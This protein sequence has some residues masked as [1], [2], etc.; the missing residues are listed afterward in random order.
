M[1]TVWIMKRLVNKIK[2]GYYE[3]R[4]AG[5][6]PGYRGDFDMENHREHHREDCEACLEGRCP[7]NR[8]GADPNMR[9][10]REGN[11]VNNIESI[12]WVLFDEH[13]HVFNLF[14]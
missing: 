3:E 8:V 11:N 9:R 12:P 1:S 14:V 5:S 7:R 2:K 6:G 10:G 13:D 4:T